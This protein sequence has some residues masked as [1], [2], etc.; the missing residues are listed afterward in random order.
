LS[1]DVKVIKYGDPKKGAEESV[2]NGNLELVIRVAAQA[3]ALTPVDSGILRNSIMW[4]VPGKNGGRTEGNV[5]Q[6]EPKKDSGI[7]G[8]ATEYAAYVEFGTRRQAAQPY[9]RPAVQIE[10]MGPNGA[11]V[12]KEESIKAMTEAL[13]KGRKLL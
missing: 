7:V 13:T 6:V 11:N 3:K 12:M 2:D 4:K 5:L 10:V 1:K 8:S 9:L